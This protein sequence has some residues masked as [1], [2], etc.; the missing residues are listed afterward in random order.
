MTINSRYSYSV[1]KQHFRLKLHFLIQIQII[2]IVKTKTRKADIETY[3]TKLPN[4]LN[5]CYRILKRV[6][7]Y[8]VLKYIKHNF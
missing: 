4:S 1:N 7:L 3:Q 2:I 6:N 5:H 8:T